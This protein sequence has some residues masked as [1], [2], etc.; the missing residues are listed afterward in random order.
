MKQF[1]LCLALA[2]SAVTA[3]GQ[4][5]FT[6]SLRTATNREEQKRWN[7]YKK[8][9]C[10]GVDNLLL[11]GG[12]GTTM[13]FKRRYESGKLIRVKRTQA[14]RA[15]VTL[16]VSQSLGDGQS[17][18]QQSD[19]LSRVQ[20]NNYVYLG[21]GKEIQQNLGRFQFFYGLDVFGS[22]TNF[23]AGNRTLG[24]NVNTGELHA[25]SQTRTTSGLRGGV[26]PF[27]GVRYFVLPRVSLAFESG[28]RVAYAVERDRFEATNELYELEVEFD[29]RKKSLESRILAK[30]FFTVNFHF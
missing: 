4:N 26:T 27:V 6:D 7:L 28:L 2:V 23:R 30:R 29:D 13:L 15:V 22:F 24:Y 20:D 1:F 21:L 14:L 3:I 8:E 12:G 25:E 19:Y 16:D 10:F 9:L 11:G 17:E 5:S 18:T